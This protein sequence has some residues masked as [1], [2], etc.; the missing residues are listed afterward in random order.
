MR[1]LK[2]WHTRTRSTERPLSAVRS[3]DDSCF[4]VPPSLSSPARQALPRRRRRRRWTEG[5]PRRPDDHRCTRRD[6][7]ERSS[8]GPTAGVLKGP[9]MGRQVPAGRSADR[10]TSH[11][12]QGRWPLQSL[13]LICAE[14]GK[15]F[16]CGAHLPPSCCRTKRRQVSGEC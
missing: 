7:L 12:P 16:V 14:C 8:L 5:V 15:K 3:A 1:S 9:D 13:A 4:D 10:S 6:R 2:P 11:A